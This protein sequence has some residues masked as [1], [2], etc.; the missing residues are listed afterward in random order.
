MNYHRSSTELPEEVLHLLDQYLQ[1]APAMIP[2]PVINDMD[3]QA[4]TLWHPDLHLDNIFVDPSTHKITRIIDWQAAAVM[5]FYYQGGVA[6]MFECPWTVP[7][8]NTIPALPDNYDTLDKNEQKRIESNRKT[9]ICYKYYKV[10][11]LGANPRHWAALLLKPQNL[12]RTQ[13]TRLVTNVWSDHDVF[14]LRRA[15][16]SIAEQWEDLCPN[17]GE[18]P[19]SFSGK[20]ME[21]HEAEEDGLAD[22]ADILR[23]FRDILGLQPD[24]MVEP[25]RFEEIKRELERMKEEFVRLVREDG[26]EERAG[27]LWPFLDGECEG[28]RD[29]VMTEP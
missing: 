11:T 15:L 27:R 17:L 7:D 5:P 13:P 16:L 28:W 29:V 23:M 21:L 18:C 14:F 6:R 4:S 9:E 26:E 19:V 8:D 12:V 3:Q 20:E 10:V 25:A 24:G 22:A 2:P 1:L